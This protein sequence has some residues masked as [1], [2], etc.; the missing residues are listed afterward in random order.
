MKKYF[1]YIVVVLVGLFFLVGC[2][3]NNDRSERKNVDSLF[4]GFSFGMERRAF[5][6]YCW[7]MNRKKIFTHGPT[8]QN[9]E[10]RLTNLSAPVSM[11]FYP[12]FYNEKIYQMPVTFTYEAW[13]P[14]NA[15]YKADSLIVEI[16]PLFKKWYG[17]EFKMVEHQTQGKV[18]YKVD[19][20]RRIN[21]FIKDD[22]FVQA[23]FTDL[24]AEKKRKDEIAKTQN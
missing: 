3:P 17:D 7:E 21:L 4:L 18:Y 8:N 11:R 19:G 16:L 23:V 15:K 1:I 5:F 22:Q 14:W 13:A 20:H 9:V 12:G 10:Y 2:K 24:R 6:E